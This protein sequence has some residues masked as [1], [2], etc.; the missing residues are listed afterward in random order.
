MAPQTSEDGAPGVV[1]RGTAQE[2][3][4][5]NGGVEGTSLGDS[6]W[7]ARQLS[8]WPHMWRRSCQHENKGVM[9]AVV[10]CLEGTVFDND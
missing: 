6:R 3:C 5:E 9:Y 10:G 8:A 7:T 1:Q 2:R 4:R